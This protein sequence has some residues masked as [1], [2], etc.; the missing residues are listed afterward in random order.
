M[1]P[2]RSCSLWQAVQARSAMSC[3]PAFS[4]RGAGRNHHR[5]VGD[6]RLVTVERGFGEIHAAPALEEDHQRLD[7]GVARL[8][9]GMKEVARLARG[10]TIDS[11]R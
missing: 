8:N 4:P 2:S 3:S 11:H 10:S 9:L 7:V 5:D 6:V 1:P